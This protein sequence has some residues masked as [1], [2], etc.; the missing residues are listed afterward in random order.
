MTRLRSRQGSGP[1]RGP[2]YDYAK[3]ASAVR[4]G[5]TQVEVARHFGCCVPTV[6]DACIQHGVPTPRWRGGR[7]KAGSA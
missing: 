3:L 4:G 2:Y 6:K 5:A 1:G 7:K